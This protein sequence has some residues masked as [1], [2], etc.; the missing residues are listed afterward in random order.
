MSR[1]PLY[2]K[3]FSI[4]CFISPKTSPNV[5]KPRILFF[6]I[7]IFTH[8]H[9]TLKNQELQVSYQMFYKSGASNL[10]V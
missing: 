5:C 7:W 4:A 10:P 3:I 9:G 1:I 8:G 6:F 2:R